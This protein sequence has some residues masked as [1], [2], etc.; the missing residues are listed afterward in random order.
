M[1]FPQSTNRAFSALVK[2]NWWLKGNNL[3]C[4]SLLADVVSLGMTFLRRR[5]VDILLCLR[6][7]SLASSQ[8]AQNHFFVVDFFLARE[9]FWRMFEHSFPAFAFLFLYFE[10]EISSRTLTPLFLP[11]SVHSG[12]T[13]WDDRGRMFPDK[14]RVSSFPDKFP[15]CAWTAA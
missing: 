14:V 5:R 6:W 1:H 15:H 13:G 8:A 11:G 12:S 4:T 3:F 2:P 9:D 10:V 7:K